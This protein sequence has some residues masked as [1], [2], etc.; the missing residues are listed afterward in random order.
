MKYA[1]FSQDKEIPW[2]LFP[3]SQQ[4]FDYL[5][6]LLGFELQKSCLLSCSDNCDDVILNNVMLG[7]CFIIEER[8]H[9]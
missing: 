6:P 1:R 5:L 8:S 4:T 9:P 2:I 3:L 7:K